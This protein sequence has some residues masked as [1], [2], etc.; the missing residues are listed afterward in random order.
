MLMY[1]EYCFR[2]MFPLMTPCMI[3]RGQVEAESDPI[4]EDTDLQQVKSM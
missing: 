1:L 3:W 4:T 2:Y